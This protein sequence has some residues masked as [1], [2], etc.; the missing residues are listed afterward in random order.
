[1]QLLQ[2]EKELSEYRN[3]VTQLEKEMNELS[4]DKRKPSGGEWM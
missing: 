3:Q 4:I 2:N 1:M